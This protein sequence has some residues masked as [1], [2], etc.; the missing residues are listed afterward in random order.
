M[1]ADP[2]WKASRSKVASGAQE[3]VASGA[4]ELVASGAQEFGL[5]Y[6]ELPLESLSL[7]PLQF[8]QPYL[9]GRAASEQR[10]VSSEQSAV[11]SE[12]S[13]VESE[14]WAVSSQQRVMRG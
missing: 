8:G 6:L 4:Q 7:Q 2:G 10:T 5:R 1:A 3:L 13:A 9:I 12:Q 14:Q 11:D